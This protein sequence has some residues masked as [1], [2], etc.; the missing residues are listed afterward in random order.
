MSRFR[1]AFGDQV[2]VLHSALSDGERADAWRLLRRGERR[3][4]VGARSAIFAPVQDLGIIVLDEE[5][6]ASYKNGETPRYHA[7]DVAAVRA[8]IEGARLVLGSATPSLETMAQ[9]ERRLRL[10]RLPGADRRPAAAAGGARRPARRAQGERDRRASAGRRRSTRPSCAT[11][12]RGEQALL[13]LNRRGFAAFLQCPD[14]GEVWQCPRCSISLTVHSVAARAPLPLLRP[15]GAAAVHLPRV[16]QPGAA[17][18]RRSAPSSSSGSWPSATPR[19]GSRGWTST[20]RAPSGRTSGSSASVETGEVDL[21]L[22]TQ[23]I[24]KGLDFPNVT[25]VGRGGRGHR[26][27]PAGLP[28]GRA[29]L[30]AA[31]AGGGARGAGAQG[32]AGAGADA[33][34]GAPRAGL[35]ARS[36]TPRGSSARSARCASRRRI[37]RRRRWSTCWCRGP[38]RRRWASGAAE[39]ADWCAALVGEIRAAGD[40]ARAGAV[41]ARADQGPL[42]LARAARRGRRRRS[43]GSCATRRARLPRAGGRAGRDRSGS[44]VVCSEAPSRARRPRTAGSSWLNAAERADTRSPAPRYNRSAAAPARTPAR[45]PR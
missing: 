39:L 36:T 14:C 37:R 44:G 9:A 41:P 6:E 5:H 8:R 35:G 10:L 25:L 16:R 11:L 1:G 40:A 12:A 28:V 27:L 38:T 3:V 30:P 34:S 15:R 43:A 4:A 20:P 23:M 31:G 32:R 13:L 45:R 19:R 18:A 42:A 7:R 29:D 33:T 21:L 2:A 17:D 22:G 26:A 24:A